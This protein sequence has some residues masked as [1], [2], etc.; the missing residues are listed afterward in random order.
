MKY[1]LSYVLIIILSLLICAS[2][3]FTLSIT[4]DIKTINVPALYT[5]QLTFIDSTT[6]SI[7]LH[8]PLQSS[9][10]SPLLTVTQNGI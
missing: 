7:T 6:R 4:V 3:N 10:T 8:F 1:R 2:S 5:Y 9:L